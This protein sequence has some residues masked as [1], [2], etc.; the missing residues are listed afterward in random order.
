MIQS[1]VA[2]MGIWS[3]WIFGAILI[4]I[5]VFAPGSFFLWFG[6]AAFVVGL[7]TMIFGMENA[8][9]VWQAQV[10]VFVVLALAFAVIGRSFMKKRGWDKSEQP[11]L[12]NRGAQ[13]IGRHAILTQPISQGHGRA[14]IG[15]STWR[16]A[17]PDMPEGSKVVVV[18]AQSSTLTVEAFEG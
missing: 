15:D 10:I 13:L 3:W 12:N 7:I 1:F 5:E 9:W 11:N 14:K 4:G 17:G 2:A 8:I 6:L 16:V 18:S